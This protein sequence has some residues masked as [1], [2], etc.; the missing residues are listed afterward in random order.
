MEIIPLVLWHCTSLGSEEVAAGWPSN[1]SCYVL[2]ST[3]V[4]ELSHTH[5]CTL[6]GRLLWER[7]TPVIDWIKRRCTFHV[8]PLLTE[9]GSPLGSCKPQ[10]LHIVRPIFKR[11][12]LNCTYKSCIFTHTQWHLAATYLC[13]PKCLLCNLGDYLWKLGNLCYGPIFCCCIKITEWATG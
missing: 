8:V 2:E 1:F 5:P 11:A 3:Y 9:G 13:S 7:L 10:P 6:G 4:V 12:N